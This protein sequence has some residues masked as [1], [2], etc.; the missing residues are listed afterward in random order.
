MVAALK[1]GKDTVFWDRELTGFGVRVHPT[2]RKVYIVKTRYR[3]RPV[4]VTI[5]PHGAVTPADARTR[6]AEIMS[7][8]RAGKDPATWNRANA[9]AP[10][11]RELG[12]RFLDE[13]VPSHCKSSTTE[14]YHRSVELFIDPR[15]GNRQV[16]D[17]QRSDIA[18]LHHDM[19]ETHYQAN[20]TLGVLSKIFNLAEL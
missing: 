5:G 20:R 9:K 6:A 8:A 15:I 18:A 19:W 14:E 17:I 13:Y 10:T 7:D 4:K 16:P 2:G 1:V 3:G 11:M 12:K